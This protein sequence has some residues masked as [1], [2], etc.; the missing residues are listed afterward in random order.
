MTGLLLNERIGE[1]GSARII[2]ALPAV[3]VFAGIESAKRIS[4]IFDV[5]IVAYVTCIYG[6][7]ITIAGLLT[8]GNF[9]NIWL[10]L[11]AIGGGILLSGVLYIRKTGRNGKKKK[12]V[13]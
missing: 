5:R 11:M 8:E 3:A 9:R 2:Y 1:G 4:G 7:L 12:V 6:S 10:H 13:W